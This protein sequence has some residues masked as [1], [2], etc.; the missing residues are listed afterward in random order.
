MRPDKGDLDRT[1]ELFPVLAKK[2]TRAQTVL[3]AADV[4]EQIFFSGATYNNQTF[5]DRRSIEHIGITRKALQKSI[6]KVMAS[7]TV[8][9]R[10]A[11]VMSAIRQFDGVS[12]IPNNTLTGAASFLMFEDALAIENAFAA[13]GDAER[14]TGHSGK[15]GY[16][17]IEHRTFSRYPVALTAIMLNVILHKGKFVPADLKSTDFLVGAEMNQIKMLH[18]PESLIAFTKMKRR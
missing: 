3:V 5:I 16:R 12:T 11:L 10:G 15:F 14:R 17:F 7:C 9:A 2:L 1:K 8:C 18:T 6:P 13:S 4:I